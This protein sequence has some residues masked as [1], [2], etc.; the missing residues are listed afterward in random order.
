M[1]YGGK[2][3]SDSRALSVCLVAVSL[4]GIG[5]GAACLAAAPGGQSKASAALDAVVKEYAHIEGAGEE[6]DELRDVSEGAFLK[7]IAVRRQLLEKSRHIDASGLTEP[8]SIDRRL[9]IGLLDSS[10]HTAEAQRIWANDAALYVPASE[11]GRLLEPTAP[12][13][14]Q[15]RAASLT[16]L[17][18]KLPSR[19][20]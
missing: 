14:P 13:S 18:A 2:I 19:L 17:L 5:G 4:L 15:E 3:H 6:L 20:D 12:G 1:Q 11:I 10:I 8:E 7:E 9:I 16:T